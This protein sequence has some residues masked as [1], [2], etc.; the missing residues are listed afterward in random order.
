MV[1]SSK[2]VVDG[3]EQRSSCSRYR[4]DT[5]SDL[6]AQGF[7]PGEVNLTQLQQEPCVDGWTYSKDIYQSTIVTE[8]DIVCSDQWKQP[9]TTTVYFSG[10]LF[11]SFVLGQVSDR[12]GRK[13]VFFGTIAF[14]ALSMFAQAFSSS[15]IMFTTFIF[16]TGVGHIGN[17]VSAFVLGAEILIGRARVMFTTLG[18][19]LS[20]A[21][22]YMMVPLLAYFLRN[23]KYLQMALALP[24]LLYLP[25]WWFIPESPR[26]LLSQG[27]VEEAEAIMQK[28]AHT[29]KVKAPVV[30]FEDFN[31][32]DEEAKNEKHHTMLDL[33][34]TSNIRRTTIILCLLWFSMCTGYYGISLNT[35]KL[36]PDPYLGSLFSAAVEVPASFCIWFGLK[37]LSRRILVGGSLFIGGASFLLKLAIPSS[38]LWL[39]VTM[40]MIG[41]PNGT[42]KYSYGDLLHILPSGKLPRPIHLTTE[43]EINIPTPS[44][45]GVVSSRVLYRSRLSSRD[46]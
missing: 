10:I 14:Q 6:W 36:T 15:W 44:G 4:L 38:L 35:S 34:R 45:D 33:F 3:E 25:F 23:W 12:F 16:F 42:E 5:V 9:L 46:L 37:H 43:F 29:N 20:F 30:I 21:T 1:A 39:T 27:R 22:G 19:G 11:G 40:E 18:M 28:A 31:T 8:F 2:R 26:W 7:A 13:P 41:L 17:L 24:S 32:G